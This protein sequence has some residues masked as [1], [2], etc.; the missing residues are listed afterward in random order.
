MIVV[1]TSDGHTIEVSEKLRDA[2]DFMRDAN[3]DDGEGEEEALVVMHATKRHFEIAQSFVDLI[4]DENPFP[5]ITPSHSLEDLENIV[6]IVFAEFVRQ[7]DMNEV[8]P[9]ILAADFLGMEDLVGLLCAH[10]SLSAAN[11][12]IKPEHLDPSLL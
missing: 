7:I 2:S 11:G 1:K 9:L 8:I 12:L 4:T 10:V 3:V 5:Q 6:G